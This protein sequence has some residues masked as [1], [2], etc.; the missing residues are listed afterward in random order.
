MDCSTVGF[1]ALHHL[2]EFAQTHVL[3]SAMP[4][5]HLTP[6]SSC[7]QSFPASG[8]F[9]NESALCIRGPKYW[10]FRISHSNEYSGLISFRIDWFDLVVQGT[11]KSQKHQ[12]FGFNLLYSPIFTLVH[13]YQKNHSL[14]YICVCM[15]VCVCI[16]V[17]IHMLIKIF[18]YI[19]SNLE[20]IMYIT[21]LEFMRETVRSRG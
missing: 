17:C 1:P 19:S 13:D 7:P 20:I 10:S 4:S 2:L 16:H 8:Y 5:N 6:F 21:A 15:C 18:M 12:F 3:E 11:L 9:S 14:F